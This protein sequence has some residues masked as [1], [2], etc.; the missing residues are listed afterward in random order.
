MEQVSARPALTVGR[1]LYRLLGM[2]QD[3]KI[4]SPTSPPS[5]VEFKSLGLCPWCGQAK[6]HAV[7]PA[8]MLTLG[9][10]LRLQWAHGF[11][12]PELALTTVTCGCPKEA[13]R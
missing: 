7:K 13:M 5:R 3:S 8:E 4:Q 11:K 2:L 6:I 12:I 9:E 1:L 10:L